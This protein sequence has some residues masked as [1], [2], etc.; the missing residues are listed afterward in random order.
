MA[1]VYNALE[2]STS[3]IRSRTKHF[4]RAILDEFTCDDFYQALVEQAVE[5]HPSGDLC[6][7]SPFFWN[8][9]SHESG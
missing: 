8:L 1:A 5:G 9:F 3:N 7:H 4:S 6:F 2:Y